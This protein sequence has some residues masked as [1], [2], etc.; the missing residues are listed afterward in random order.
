VKDVAYFLSSCLSSRECERQADGYLDAYFDEL[1]RALP[2]RDAE[3]EREWRELFPFAWA[4]FQ[5]FL[6]GWAGGQ[7]ER[8][9]YANAL[10]EVLATLAAP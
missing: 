2:R 10:V 7:L 6:L 3:L 5:R 8:D 1:Q 4:D 9:R